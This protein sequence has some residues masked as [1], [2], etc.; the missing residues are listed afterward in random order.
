MKQPRLEH[1]TKRMWL[2]V[3]LAIAYGT[4]LLYQHTLTGSNT[5][6]GIIGVLLGVYICAHP[7]AHL[8]DLLYLTHEARQQLLSRQSGM[9]WLGLNALVLLCGLFLIII[10]A[11]RFVQPA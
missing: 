11:N 2:A 1:H 6:D 5:L 10:G 9:V 7:S 3:L 4:V 8:L